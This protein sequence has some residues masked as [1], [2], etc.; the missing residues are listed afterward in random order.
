MAST[1]LLIGFMFATL[2]FAFMPGPAMIYTAAQTMAGGRA[3]GF[4]AVIGIHIGGWFHVIC[5][6]AGLSALLVLV[7]A[8][9]LV[10]KLLGAAYLVYL[11]AN[12]VRTAWRQRQTGLDAVTVVPSRSR[13]RVMLNS[14]LVEVLNPKA[15]LFFLAFLPQFVDPGAAL[16]AWL[17]FLILGTIVNLTFSSADVVCVIFAAAIMGRMPQE[18]DDACWTCACDDDVEGCCGRGGGHVWSFR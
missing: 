11:G 9:Y 17:Q 5:A 15:A 6:T 16:P 14:I 4:R 18:P 10:I 2:A 8:V 3:A 13:T 7:P 1:S 12:L